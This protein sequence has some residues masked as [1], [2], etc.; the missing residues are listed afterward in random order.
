MPNNSEK[1]KVM[2]KLLLTKNEPVII[3][4]L[5]GYIKEVP[6]VVGVDNDIRY[7]LL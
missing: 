2:S 1:G 3:L 6:I 5:P 7:G 4:R